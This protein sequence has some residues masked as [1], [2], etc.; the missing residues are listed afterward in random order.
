MNTALAR[1]LERTL[2]RLAPNDLLMPVARG[3]KHPMFPHKDGRWSRQQSESEFRKNATAAAD[4]D[5]CVL[6]KDLCVVDVDSERV[7]VALEAE[8]PELSAAPMEQTRRGRHYWFRRSAECDAGGYY[9]GA[10]QVREK[11]D[12]KTR[13]STGTAGV[14]VVAPSKGKRWVRAI[15]AEALVDVPRRLLEAVARPTV[16]FLPGRDDARLRFACGSIATFPASALSRMSYFEPFLGGDLLGDDSSWAI[17]VPCTL[18]EFSDV[19][20]LLRGPTT[21][22]PLH[23]KSDSGEEEDDDSGEEEEEEDDDDDDDDPRRKSLVSNL[24]ADRGDHHTIDASKIPGVL[25]IADRLGWDAARLRGKASALFRR[26]L[27]EKDRDPEMA[28]AVDSAG[29]GDDDLYDVFW[30]VRFRRRPKNVPDQA[31]VFADVD[32]SSVRH[33]EADRPPEILGEAID[34]FWNGMDPVVRRLLESHPEKLTLAGGAVF[35]LLTGVAFG[36]YDLFLTVPTA[37]E[38][39]AILRDVVGTCGRQGL[40]KRWSSKNATTL[41]SPESGVVVQVV[42]RLYGSPADV[43]AGFDI[44]AAMACAYVTS[45]SSSSSQGQGGGGGGDGRIIARHEFF[46]CIEQGAFEV[47]VDRWSA[48]SIHRILKYRSR[49]LSAY[50][51]GLR[52]K[53]VRSL[54]PLSIAQDVVDPLSTQGIFLSEAWLGTNMRSAAS[55]DILNRM[56]RGQKSGYGDRDEHPFALRSLGRKFCRIVA[57]TLR[58]WIGWI[59]SSISYSSTEQ[60]QKKQPDEDAVDWTLHR[61]GVF[62]QRSSRFASL[63]E[64]NA[65]N[66]FA[67]CELSIADDIVANLPNRDVVAFDPRKISYEC[68]ID[69]RLRETVERFPVSRF[70]A[71][72]LDAL[73]DRCLSTAALFDFRRVDDGEYV[74]TTLDRIG[75]TERELKAALGSIARVRRLFSDAYAF[76]ICSNFSD[77][78]TALDTIMCMDESTAAMLMVDWIVSRVK[79]S[80]NNY[81]P[82][83]EQD[84]ENYVEAIEGLRDWFVNVWYVEHG[85]AESVNLLLHRI[86]EIGRP[87]ILQSNI[88]DKLIRRRR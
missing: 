11:V 70:R 67:A 16:V 27:V 9:D 25:A 34:G 5:V 29:G 8:F 58:S 18:R 49:G 13:T 55:F 50:L 47:R 87:W 35:G 32:F 81:N 48:A 73:K 80:D 39:D 72:V 2:E 3:G 40:T 53:C 65:Y 59:A 83:S 42:H 1:E 78:Q 88:I 6:L 23:E 60:Q 12:F 71:S 33:G 45:P 86:H 82:L 63:H 20:S 61:N 76:E 74:R 54:P 19:V 31:Y 36:D 17:P 38:A 15:S 69:K 84:M 10:A 68:M 7:A 26:A 77:V 44:S 52:R 30:P 56:L 24:G 14:V 21:P 75:A 62:N 22:P 85:P 64:P 46:V 28:A 41:V 4:A 79:D 66:F 51:P 57:G 43:V 37:E